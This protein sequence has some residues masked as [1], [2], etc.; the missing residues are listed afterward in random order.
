[1]CHYWYT[2][3][4]EVMAVLEVTARQFRDNQRVCFEQ[5]DNGSQIV[6]KRGRKK[7][8]I[9]MP[10]SQYNFDVTPELLKQIEI[11][12]QQIREGK[13]ITC[14]TKEDLIAHLDSL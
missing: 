14:K 8:Y 12:R 9:L 11:S 10:I 3:Y 5:A 4:L 7:S 2:F 6:I 13:C 1:M